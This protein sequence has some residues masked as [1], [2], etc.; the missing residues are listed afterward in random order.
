MRFEIEPSQLLSNRFPFEKDRVYDMRNSACPDFDAQ[1]FFSIVNEMRT[2][3]QLAPVSLAELQ[4]SLGRKGI[5]IEV[6]DTIG[7]IAGVPGNANL[8]LVSPTEIEKAQVPPLMVIIHETLHILSIDFHPPEVLTEAMTQFLTVRVMDEY[9]RRT[10][11]VKDTVNHYDKIRTFYKNNVSVLGSICSLLSAD[12]GVDVATIENGFIS[13]YFTGDIDMYLRDITSQLPP[14]KR[15]IM[16]AFIHAEQ[17]QIFDDAFTAQL[18]KKI[19][20]LSIP[21]S[22]K[23]IWRKLVEMAGNI[24]V[25]RHEQKMDKR[26]VQ[27]LGGKK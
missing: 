11:T 17:H 8:I 5:Q 7:S 10:G 24:R 9:L 16:N 27:I 13:A 1:V 2:R 18:Q 14:I 20:A 15:E 22:E 25:R 12:T 3:A 21:D 26:K 4:D 6:D 23:G 19:A